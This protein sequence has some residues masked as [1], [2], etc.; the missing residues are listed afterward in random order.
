LNYIFLAI[1]GIEYRKS[2]LFLFITRTWN[3]LYN[4]QK[5]GNKHFLGQRPSPH[6]MPLFVTSD[7]SI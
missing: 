6:I 7:Y 2:I 4:N 3:F 5:L 1:Y